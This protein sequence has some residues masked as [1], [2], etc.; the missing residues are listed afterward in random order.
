M[1]KS[2]RI[3]L[4]I[5]III[6]IFVCLIVTN[7]SRIRQCFSYHKVFAS[8]T[9]RI[10]NKE[11]KICEVSTLNTISHKPQ[12]IELSSRASNTN[13]SLGYAGLAL[14][15]KEI[16][17]IR[18][19][20]LTLIFECKG[21]SIGFLPPKKP[22]AFSD[23]EY[24]TYFDRE[25]LPGDAFDAQVKIANILPK[26]YLQIFFM[27]KHEFNEYMT[28]C[29]LKTA[30]MYNQNGIGI[31]ENDNIKGVIGFGAAHMPYQMVA[32]VYSKNTSVAQEIMV[33]SDSAEKTKT[34]LFSI[35]SSYKYLIQQPL[36]DTALKEAIV[37]ALSSHPLFHLEPLEDKTTINMGS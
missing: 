15:L 11:G 18:L 2:T 37:G 33:M 34:I 5:S 10:A 9:S 7:Y 6:F 22:R 27:P 20:G 21:Y 35:L 3:V 14:E 4:V 19:S 16:I 30:N 31:F 26:T 1:N 32:D 13:L 36:D 23:V 12:R 17:K 28:F 29:F 24:V 25:L 8:D